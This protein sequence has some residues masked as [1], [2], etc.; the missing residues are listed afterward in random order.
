MAK[1]IVADSLYSSKQWF[2]SHLD[3]YSH[4]LQEYGEEVEA[5][6][7][8]AGNHWTAPD[9]LFML[10]Q[11]GHFA[12]TNNEGPW[13]ETKKIAQVAAVCSPMPWEV[14]KSDGLPAYDLVISSIPNMVEQARAAGCRAEYQALA[15]DHRALVCEAPKKDIDC[16]FVG[17]VDANHR[18]RQEVLAQLNGIVTVERP[19]FGRAYYNLVSRAHVLLHVGAEWSVGSANALRLF[20]GAGLRAV[21]VSDGN[22]DGPGEEWWRRPKANDW[23]ATV[24][25]AV[26]EATFF[27][28]RA[29]RHQGQILAEHGYHRRIPQ[30]IEW[31]RGL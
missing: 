14:R 2:C 30:L 21:V 7:H 12:A 27:T 8:G 19:T 13:R 15:F 25:S 16:L 5:F 22:W 26:A 28:H 29:D 3:S 10:D 24:K 18:K 9:V 31:S 23:N 20:E 4:Y 11:Y 1:W 6:E 17:T